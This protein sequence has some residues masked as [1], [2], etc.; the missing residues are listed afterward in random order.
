[1]LALR[2]VS[3]TQTLEDFGHCLVV[4]ALKLHVEPVHLVLEGGLL[5]QLLRL[6]RQLKQADGRTAV[7]DSLAV[8]SAA[9]ASVAAY[10]RWAETLQRTRLHE[11][12]PPVLLS[13]ASTADTTSTAEPTMR[14]LSEEKRVYVK[15]VE[16]S[17]LQVAFSLAFGDVFRSRA[18]DYYLLKDG[19]VLLPAV[20][21]R[22]DEPRTVGT[23]LARLKTVYA[24]AF[25][26]QL[27]NVFFYARSLAAPQRFVS[28]LVRDLKAFA[29]ALYHASGESNV[30]RAASQTLACSST[31][32]QECL[33]NLL[34]LQVDVVM[35]AL[36]WGYMGLQLAHRLL[37][38]RWKRGYVTKY[39]PFL[40]NHKK[41][42]NWVAMALRA[43]TNRAVGLLSRMNLLVPVEYCLHHLDIFRKTVECEPRRFERCKP[44]NVSIR[45]VVLV[46]AAS[47]CEP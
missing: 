42:R 22:E 6:L 32:A 4:T 29:D 12:N 21:M 30:I 19:H 43:M 33:T 7:G 17:T 24:R 28:A 25:L 16:V 13:N 18:Y 37:G 27:H 40:L 10:A 3:E 36:S 1:M 47:A 44:P 38:G 39:S 20:T 14:S 45:G 34:V 41:S 46:S 5:R 23:L 8:P 9:R 2:L 26:F 11:R 31:F 35:S 15:S